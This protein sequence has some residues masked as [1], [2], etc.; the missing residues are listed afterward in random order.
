MT[1]QEKKE[2]K[3]LDTDAQAEQFI[4]LFW[5]RRDPNLET[6]VNE[7]KRDFD[8][9]VAAADKL[10]GFAKTPGWE[11]DRGRTLI[12][13]GNPTKRSFQSAGQVND[14][15]MGTSGNPATGQAGSGAFQEN[16]GGEI[17]EYGPETLPPGTKPDHVYFVFRE[18][19]MGYGDYT[20]DRA[21]RTNA[22]AMRL[23]A[24][25][26]ERTVLHPKLT[27]VPSVGIVAGSKNATPDQLAV[28]AA[29]DKPWPEGAG[30]VSR[31]GALSASDHP[32]WLWLQL[33]DGV[34]AASQAVGRVTNAAT[35]EVVGTFALDAKP[36]S[37]PS[38][39]G[40]EFSFPLAV[41]EYRIDVALLGANGPL[42]VKTFDGKVEGIPGDGEYLS[43]FLWG[44]DVRQDTG[45][46]LGDPFD[47]GGWHIIPRV[48]NTFTTDES[49]N[50]FCTIL[51]PTL[52]EQGKGKFEI[53][54]ALYMGERKLTE[55]PPQPAQIS[56]IHGDL[57][58]FGHG[59]PLQNFRQGGDFKLV[60]T[61]KDTL[62][63]V[64]KST[65]IPM[66]VEK[67]G[68]KQG[69]SAK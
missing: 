40:Y 23:L 52:D 26:P 29:A 6:S 51:R 37:V 58:M 25:A 32:F 53:T 41:G 21:D 45:A 13:M 28:F 60:V 3:K 20:L 10:Y 17:W 43:P 11:S 65:E 50:Y 59:L 5:A 31:E 36:V 27:E 66:T 33:P 22:Q 7:F 54:L 35:G 55:T 57:W 38:G 15:I 62:S 63:N 56:H 67:L 39:R 2:F 14:N 64:S 42:A 12:L 47:I 34:P 1:K 69:A 68:E 49:V 4:A 46:K 8:Q 44:A 16:G 24:E 18:S 9:R 61:V 19:R 48:G 30:F